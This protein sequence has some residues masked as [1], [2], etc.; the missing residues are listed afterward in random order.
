MRALGIALSSAL[1]LGV[2]TTSGDAHAADRY[3]DRAMTLPRLNFAGD[4]GLGI[5]HY[6]YRDEIGAGMNL[7][8]ALG[9]TNRFELGFRTGI[10]FGDEGRVIHAD[11]YGRTNW[12]ETYGTAGGTVANP[13]LRLRWIAYSGSVAEVGLDGR[14]FLPIE[15]G[16]N[17]GMMFGVPFAFHAASFLRIDLG[18]YMPMIFDDPARVALTV[19]AY[20]WFQ[21]TDK[22]WLGPMTSLRFN[23]NRPGNDDVD[24]VTGIG[25]GYQV[26]SAVDLKWMLLF[27]RFDDDL[28]RTIGGGFGAQFRIE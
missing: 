2:L 9:I 8:A 24:F 23:F 10:R 6:R 12:T 14:F 16:S 25:M 4:V 21:A 15:N 28:L 20:F 1:A 3:V 27:N 17:F 18:V 11:E 13:E 22:F 26:A 5:G 7:E 19:P